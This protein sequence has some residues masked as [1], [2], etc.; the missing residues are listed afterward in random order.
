MRARG[1]AYVS[2]IQQRRA[3]SWRTCDRATATS[4]TTYTAMRGDWQARQATASRSWH[5]AMATVPLARLL[6][7]V[8]AAIAVLAVPS[9]LAADTG[10]VLKATEE[11]LVQLTV[12][13]WSAEIKQGAW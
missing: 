6:C 13:N 10:S 8:L 1:G 4:T 9:T 5:S 2:M 3:S 7:A 11:G 12:A